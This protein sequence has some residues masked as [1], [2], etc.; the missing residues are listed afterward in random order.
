M[1]KKKR[2]QIVRDI[3]FIMKETKLSS[4]EV[5]NLIQ[6]S[7]KSPTAPLLC[8]DLMISNRS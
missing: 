4:E 2:L 1:L 5:I 8:N 7:A 6:R 3:R